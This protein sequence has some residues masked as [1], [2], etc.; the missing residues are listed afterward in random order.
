MVV[1]ADINESNGKSVAADIEGAIY[2]KV[3]VTNTL[4]V[5]AMVQTCVAEFGGL[6]ILV[7]NA[8]IVQKKTPLQDVLEE[9]FDKI[10]AVNVKSIFFSAVHVIPVMKKKG[11]VIINLGSTGA[12]RPRPGLTW[13]NA[14]KGAV[15]TL[16]KSMAVE[17]AD[18]NIRVNA[19]NP[20]ISDTAMLLD[21]LGGEDTPEGRNKL[22]STIPLGRMTAPKDVANAALYLA[23]DE[24]KFVTGVCMEVDGGR[25][26]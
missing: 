8:G 4:Q 14:S 12:V 11:G 26:I 24:A 15:V 18:D 17:L 2:C 6:D 9:D 23:S 16:T 19:V 1:V 7:N 20:A 10:F 13:Y 25:C 3:D 22:I 5:R 21:V